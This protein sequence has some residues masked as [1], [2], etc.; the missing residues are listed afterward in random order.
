MLR[1]VVPC[2]ATFSGP[3]LD[4]PELTHRFGVL[5]PDGRPPAGPS[6]DHP[7]LTHRFGVLTP[8]GRPGV[9][10]VAVLG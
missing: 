2:R 3:I 5:T 6:L 10:R 1:R 4:H 8:D 9:G 7:E